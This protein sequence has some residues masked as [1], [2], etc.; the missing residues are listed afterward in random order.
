MYN[1]RGPTEGS[2]PLVPSPHFVEETLH[3]VVDPPSN[4]ISPVSAQ[5]AQELEQVPST[6]TMITSNEGIEEFTAP[7]STLHPLAYRIPVRNANH[8]AASVDLIRQERPRHIRRNGS[9]A[10]LPD[11]YTDSE[12]IDSLSPTRRLG[13]GSRSATEMLLALPSAQSP[14][15]Y[16]L[17]RRE[18]FHISSQTRISERR[19]LNAPVAPR[20]RRNDNIENEPVELDSDR[21]VVS[22]TVSS[23]LA[24]AHTIQLR[25]EVGR[26]QR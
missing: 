11:R 20:S 23:P 6:D 22:V 2:S 18:D 14:S 25:D 16:V 1:I 26:W 24:R 8:L 15:G 12:L 7:E 5:M 13:H 19:H 21:T 3:E 4:E 17:S 9:V 10:M